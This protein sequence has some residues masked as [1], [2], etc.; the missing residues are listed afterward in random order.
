MLV[1]TKEFRGVAPTRGPAG[2]AT[3]RATPHISPPP[4]PPH[5]YYLTR[6]TAKVVFTGDCLFVG[7]CGKFFEGGPPQMY[8]SLYT[9]L[10]SLAPE[11]IVYVGHE[12]TLSNYKFGVSV[13]PANAKLADKVAWAQEQIRQGLPTVPTTIR[14]ETETNVFLRCTEP[15]VQET[16]VACATTTD[17]LGALRA[18][19]DSGKF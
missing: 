12:Y 11:T 2:C 19:K 13:E 6:G 16:C 14:S 3:S 5:S 4:L 10:G 9:H 1:T 18:R 17:F 15:S 7:G 8:H